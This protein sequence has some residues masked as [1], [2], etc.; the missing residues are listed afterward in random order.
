[1]VL[2]DVDIQV[3]QINGNLYI[4]GFKEDNL[5]PQS[6]DFT[7][8]PT[9]KI[10]HPLALGLAPVRHPRLAEAVGV[11]MPMEGPSIHDFALDVKDKNPKTFEFEI[12]EEG[13]ILQPNHLYLYSCN[14]RIALAPH[15]CGTVMGKSSLGR[16]GLDIHICAGFADGGFGY[17]DK[18]FTPSSLVL[19]MRT[20]YPLRIYPN[21]KICQIK[22]EYSSQPF[23]G[24]GDKP[25]SKYHGQ[26]GVVASK[27]GENFTN[28]YDPNMHR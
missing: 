2:S 21:M 1:V 20:I 11:L 19:E 10:Y 9:C 23:K 7:L 28:E 16:L 15:I 22:F 14:E 18:K 27:Y 12:G 6:Y 13:F 8:A 3:E 24:Y 25:D 26:Q 4:E 17:K 5:S